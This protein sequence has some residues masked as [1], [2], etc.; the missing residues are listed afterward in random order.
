LNTRATPC[1]LLA[2]CPN[3]GTLKLGNVEVTHSSREQP[4][5]G[6]Y[7]QLHTLHLDS[8]GAIGQ[9]PQLPSLTALLLDGWFIAEELPCAVNQVASQLTRLRLPVGTMQSLA[10]IQPCVPG[11][12]HN[13]QRLE[14]PSLVLTDDVFTSLHQLLPGLRC[15]EFKELRLIS[16][17]ADVG[18]S[19][20]EL[21]LAPDGHHSVQQLTMLPLARAGRH[22][23]GLQRL[24]LPGIHRD[25]VGGLEEISAKVAAVC[26]S[27]CRLAPMHVEGEPL[28][29]FTLGMEYI[30]RMLPLLSCFEPG[31]IC[32]LRLG[33]WD[34]MLQ[35]TL[36][37]FGAALAI[38]GGGY[39]AVARCHTLTLACTGFQDDA[40]CAAL[41]PMLMA[42]SI[43]EVVITCF[44]T[45]V[46][47]AQLAAMCCPNS[48]AA[49]TRPISLRVKCAPTD[50]QQAQ[51][52]IAAAGKAH[53][54]R[55]EEVSAHLGIL[56][57]V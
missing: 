40:T 2:A 37:A 57:A 14:L 6:T 12:T 17:H 56:W 4:T 31:S 10:T 35:S 24:V 22:T 21:R 42:T 25:R 30:V 3:L 41:L 50:V 19:W 46:T 55:L 11:L 26:S 44:G 15:V 7:P 32:S 29:Q 39:A 28:G 48:L 43:S 36:A 5:A 47:S 51:A 27:S 13:L 45:Q 23:V 9:L 1:T 20:Q 49:V 34:H 53:L 38:H 33:L 8:C 16:N 54:I 18:C 52:E